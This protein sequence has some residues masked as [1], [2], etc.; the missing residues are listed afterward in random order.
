[1]NMW[2]TL[3]LYPFLLCSFCQ[4]I[5]MGYISMFFYLFL[6]CFVV[7]LVEVI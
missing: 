3:V 5:S 1:V 2:I 7:L 6:Q 4:S